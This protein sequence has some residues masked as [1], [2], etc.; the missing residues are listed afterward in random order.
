MRQDRLHAQEW[1]IFGRVLTVLFLVGAACSVRAETAPTAAEAAA[2]TAEDLYELRRKGNEALGYKIYSTA[3]EFFRRY[4]EAANFREPEFADATELLVKAYLQLGD[5]VKAQAALGYHEEHTPGVTDPVYRDALGYWSGAVAFARG[6]WARAVAAATPLAE[7]AVSPDYRRLALALLADAH[8]RLQEWDLAEAAL[9]RVLA[10]FPN[11]APAARQRASFRLIRVFLA[12]GET[13]PAAR[14]LSELADSPQPPQPR[15]LALWRAMLLLKQGQLGEAF[16]LY[17]SIAEGRPQ[18]PD[19]E[20]WL[21]SSQLAA[22]LIRGKRPADAL[23]ILPQV[24]G[25]AGTVAERVDSDLLNIQ[26]LIA[27][28]RAE[29]AVQAMTEFRSAYPNRPELTP[30]QLSLAE[31]LA[32]KQDYAAAA[33]YFREVAVD[34]NVSGPYRYRATIRQ[35]NC[36]RAANQ[37]ED[38]VGVFSKAEELG[39]T[40][41]ERAEALCLAADAAYHIEDYTVAALHYKRGADQYPESRVAERARFL[42]ARSRAAAKLY[43]DAAQIYQRFLTEFPESELIPAAKMGRGVA[44][45]D[46]GDLA[47]AIDELRTFA[48]DY[49]GTTLAPRALLAAYEAA[50]AFDDVPQAVQILTEVIDNYR[51]A[52]LFKEALY[53]RAHVHFFQAEYELAVADCTLFLEQ[54]PLLPMAT[55]VLIWLGDYYA[56]LG[57][58]ELSGEHFLRLVNDHP[59]SPQAPSA[60]YEA[61]KVTYYHGDLDSAL[62]LLQQFHSDYPQAPGASRARADLLQGDIMAKKGSYLKALEYFKTAWE[63]AGDSPLGIAACGRYGDMLY[64]QGAQVQDAELIRTAA[65][66]FRRIAENA[67]S[68]AAQR[69]KAAYRLAKCREA[70]GETAAAI[71]AYWDVYIQYQIDLREGRIRDWFYFARSGYDVAELLLRERKFESAAR[72]YETLAQTRLPDSDDPLI[73]THA[74]AAAK[75][76]EIRS[77]H[78]LDD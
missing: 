76:R 19:P 25:L 2:P 15:D 39:Q 29:A 20:W 72:V 34:P 63:Q 48:A 24:T 28:A 55:D 59:D 77:T 46:A 71:D 58:L 26:I 14:M 78:G 40:P 4:R 23:R 16:E 11:A 45:K 47:R 69:E 5:A 67:V 41:D 33:E 62:G 12:K 57:R 61:A 21:V 50:R 60:L 54:F 70:L 53:N 66:T 35:G 64:S 3:V 68:T 9:Q 7:A 27:S 1:A 13:A 73:P 43:S 30:V 18:R 10:E 31:L 51:D 44:L 22:A 49:A 32:E 8:A 36:L 75:A 38:A 52:D 17:K 65:E 6:E 37:A 56:N 42:E 74:D